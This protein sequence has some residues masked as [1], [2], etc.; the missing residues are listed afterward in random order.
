VKLKIQDLHLMHL[1]HLGI[2]R[3]Q[4]EEKRKRE[5]VADLVVNKEV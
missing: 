3:Q 2:Q 1:Q 5:N 4:K